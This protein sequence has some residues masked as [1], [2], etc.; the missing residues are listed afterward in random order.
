MVR[1]SDIGKPTVAVGFFADVIPGEH[2]A[3]LP[4]LLQEI[5]RV[6]RYPLSE[7]DIVALKNDIR[8]AANRMADNVESRE[9]ADWVQQLSASWLQSK[10]YVSAQQVSRDALTLLPTITPQEVNRHLQRWLAASDTLVQ[11]SVLGNASFTLPTA[12]VIT[13]ELQK[14]RAV[15]LATAPLPLAKVVPELPVVTTTGKRTAVQHFPQQQVEQW[16]LANGDRVV[17]LRTPL[18]H[19]KFYLSA[20]SN[21]GFMAK[22]LNPWQAQIASQIVV[23]IGPQGCRAENLRDWKQ[24]Q[25][26]S[27]N[28]S[29]S[30]D[31]L[32]ITGLSTLKQVHS[33]FQLYHAMNTQASV[34][35]SVMK[36]SLASPMR[37]RANRSQSSGDL[38]QRE[39]TRLRFGQPAYQEPDQTQLRG[40]TAPM[41][42]TQWQQTVSVPVTYYLMANQPAETFLPLVERY[43]ASLPR[44]TQ[45]AITPH[46]ALAG[47]R[48]STVA[49]NIEPRSEVRD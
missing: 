23:Q 28:V 7:R 48:E 46:R 4:V 3:A 18:A 39:M 49:L 41:L 16:Q 36:D 13:T 30:A 19:D 25:A 11:F 34:D 44:A 27:F 15:N 12:T 35:A 42:P 24:A 38:R 45:L 17:Y 8:Q 5:E 32:Q 6:K 1:E 33:L 10:P 47:T 20:Y 21:A 43:L 40:V 22:T 9:F 37:Q 14:A 31:E 2:Q 29:Q 26:V